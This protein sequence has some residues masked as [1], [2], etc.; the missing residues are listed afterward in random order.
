MSNRSLDA[1]SPRFF[2][3]A[4][5]LLAR[6]VEAQIPVLIINT[7]RTPAEQAANIANGVSWTKNSKHLT[8]DAIDIAPYAVY[9]EVGPD[10][11]QWNAADPIWFQLGKIGEAIGLRWGGRFG[12]PAR[13][14]LGHFE[15]VDVRAHDQRSMRIA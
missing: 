6:C 14:D 5:L 9:Q 12:P 13:P 1:L 3:L 11:L 8:G 4:V 15:Y 2:P 10:K 7:L